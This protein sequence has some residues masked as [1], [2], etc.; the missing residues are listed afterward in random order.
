MS[1][2]D[3][4]SKSV[5]KPAD[6]K[7]SSETRVRVDFLGESYE[8]DV[9]VMR[10]PRTL[11][12]FKREDI[13]GALVRILGEDDLDRAIVSTEDDDGFADIERL[14]PLVEKIAEAANTKNS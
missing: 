5:K 1:E 6:H 8:F 13:E 7:P 11:F 10:D 2:V 9:R 4:K 14:S 12:A 3:T